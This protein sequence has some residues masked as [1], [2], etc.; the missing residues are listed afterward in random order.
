MLYVEKHFCQFSVKNIEFGWLIYTKIIRDGI[1]IGECKSQDKWLSCTGGCNDLGT[2][3]GWGCGNCEV[4]QAAAVEIK[5]L[6]S[7]LLIN[8]IHNN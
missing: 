5:C 7:R 2:G 6:E 3:Y 8:S 4:G 1:R